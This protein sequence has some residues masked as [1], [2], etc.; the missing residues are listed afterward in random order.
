MAKHIKPS[1]LGNY[2]KKR[3]SAFGE[4]SGNEASEVA[5]AAF[6]G[7]TRPT[8]RAIKYRTY[9]VPDAVLAKLGLE[10]VYRV[11]PDRAPAIPAKSAKAAKKK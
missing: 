2:V 4:A 3:Q 11:I 8:L 7:I 6:L 1:E 9:S 5:F 10:K